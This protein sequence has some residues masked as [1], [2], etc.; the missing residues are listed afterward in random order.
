MKLHLIT[1]A[2][3]GILSV[4]G[5]TA[6]VMTLSECMR[7]AVENSTKVRIQQAD[8]DDARIR[9]RDAILNAFTPSISASTYAY[10]NFG[11][12]VDPETN[13]YVSTASFNNGYSVSAGISLFNGFEAVNNIRIARTAMRMGISQEQQI[14]DDICLATMQAYYNAVYYQQLM[15]IMESQVETAQDALILASKQE[16]LGQKGYAYVVEMEAEL[17]DREYQLTTARNSYADAMLTLKDL[18]F[19]PLDEPLTIDVTMAEAEDVILIS[20]SDE[21]GNITGYAVRNMPSIAVAKASMENALTALKSAKWKF[22][23]SIS[24]NGGWS[25]SYY[26]YPGQQGYVPTPYWNQFRNNSGEYLQVSLSFPIFNSLSNFSNLR[27]RKNDY[28]R[29][30]LQYEQKM[31]DVEAEVA[32]AVQDRDGASAAY[33]Q[34][35]RREAVQEEAYRMNIRKLEQG[36]ISPIDYQKAADNWLNAKTTKLNALLTYYIKRSVVEYYKGIP[37][38]EQ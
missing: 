3:A 5:A 14:K 9:R 18:M 24:L 30:T 19:W 1:L 26:T 34:A 36:L 33:R 11:R 23:P 16:E 4:P 2:A 15:S 13:T 37:Y 21:L 10:S 7:Q 25:T 29:A 6:Q 22:T 8:N 28:R 38:I 20:P 35:E 31:R 32:R 27:N 12:S 17:A